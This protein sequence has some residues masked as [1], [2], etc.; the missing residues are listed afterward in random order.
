MR[1]SNRGALGR[2]QSRLADRDRARCKP[3]RPVRF[4]GWDGT[5]VAGLRWMSPSGGPPTRPSRLPRGRRERPSSRSWCSSWPCSQPSPV[6]PP[7]SCLGI[8]RSYRPSPSGSHISAAAQRM[9]PR[10]LPRRPD[11]AAWYSSAGHR[12]P[13]TVHVH[14]A[15]AD[16]RDGWRPQHRQGRPTRPLGRRALARAC[17]NANGRSRQLRSD[18][19]AAPAWTARA[20][21]ALAGRLHRDEDRPR[22][23][24]V[25]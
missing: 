15:R 21:A 1:K 3:P 25:L 12:S 14:A 7:A 8:T 20:P 13:P 2:Q 19:Q 18:E 4:G 24:T 10:P 16:G 9:A 5:I 11:A 6:S 23:V 22:P 17:A